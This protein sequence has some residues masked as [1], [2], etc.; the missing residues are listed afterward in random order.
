MQ[1]KTRT[2]SL[3]PAR[4]PVS[5]SAVC[6]SI[7]PLELDRVTRDVE[8]ET[9]EE[10]RRLRRLELARL[11]VSSTPS[12]EGPGAGTRTMGFGMGVADFDERDFDERATDSTDRG[13]SGSFESESDA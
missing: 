12:T 7:D 3:S 10:E 8:A 9:I 2:V 4:L 5:T 1:T 6:C 13:I 11:G